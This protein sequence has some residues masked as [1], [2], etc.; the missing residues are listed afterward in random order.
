VIWVID[1]SI[2]APYARGVLSV[3]MCRLRSG[4]V[5]PKSGSSGMCKLSALLL[6]ELFLGLGFLSLFI[7]LLCGFS[8]FFLE[9]CFFNCA[10]KTFP[11]LSY[12]RDIMQ[13]RI[14]VCLMYVSLFVC[15]H[16]P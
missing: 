16:I 13:V 2:T 3:R 4:C 12:L 14:F 9:R 7:F 5:L 15:A 1:T 8:C 10:R 11:R 6:V